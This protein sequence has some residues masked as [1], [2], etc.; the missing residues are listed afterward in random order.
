VRTNAGALADYFEVAGLTILGVADLGNGVPATT[1]AAYTADGDNYLDLC[2]QLP[3]RFNPRWIE[4]VTTDPAN[5]FGLQAFDPA[6]DTPNPA[7][8]ISIVN[9]STPRPAGF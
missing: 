4:Q 3:A 1:A 2:L 8:T 6:G 9:E 7:Q 5:S